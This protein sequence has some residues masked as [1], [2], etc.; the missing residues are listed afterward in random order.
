MHQKIFPTREHQLLDSIVGM[1]GHVLQN[2]DYS[3]E[4]KLLFHLQTAR[5]GQ[6]L[7]STAF[8]IT[9]LTSNA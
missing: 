9:F 7:L 4:T 3:E 8:K 2:V 6:G 1:N 5:L